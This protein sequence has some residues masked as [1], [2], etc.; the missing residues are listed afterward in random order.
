MQRAE[1]CSGL[2]EKHDY[3]YD[4]QH[5]MENVTISALPDGTYELE[6]ITARTDSQRFHLY[7]VVTNGVVTTVDE[8]TKR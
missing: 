4:I 1:R 5:S 6:E 3:R 8:T 7:L 2:V